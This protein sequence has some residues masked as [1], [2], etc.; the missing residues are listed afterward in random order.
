MCVGKDPLFI[1]SVYMLAVD[2]FF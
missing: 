1:S 2:G